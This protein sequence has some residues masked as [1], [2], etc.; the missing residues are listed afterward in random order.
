MQGIIQKRFD[1]GGWSPYIDV[2]VCDGVVLI[3]LELH[4]LVCRIIV[5]GIRRRRIGGG[6]D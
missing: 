3:V 5:V 4:L 6:V 2:D 1:C